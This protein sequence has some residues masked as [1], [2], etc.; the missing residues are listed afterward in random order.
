M[1]FDLVML[2]LTFNVRCLVSIQG[3]GSDG[4]RVKL[5]KQVTFRI[6][7]DEKEVKMTPGMRKGC[8]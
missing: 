1:S 2:L 3:F 4:N 7:G 5:K 8:G 6:R